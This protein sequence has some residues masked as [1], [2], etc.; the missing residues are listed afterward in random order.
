MSTK[1]ERTKEQKAL[2]IA[3]VI[4]SF[5]TLI[6]TVIGGTIGLLIGAGGVFILNCL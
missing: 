5:N 1:T 2:D 3:D 6:A 4:S